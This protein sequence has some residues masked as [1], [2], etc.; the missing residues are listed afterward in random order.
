MRLLPKLLPKHSANS[1]RTQLLKAIG[2]I[3]KTS[4]QGQHTFCA[5]SLHSLHDHEVTLHVS[6]FTFYEGRE[7]KTPIFVFK[8]ER[9]GIK[10][11][12]E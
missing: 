10:V 12:S 7:R 4:L 8:I 3:N 2:F 1:E 6:N 11:I 5:N 9:G